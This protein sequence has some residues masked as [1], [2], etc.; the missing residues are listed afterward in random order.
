MN[1]KCGISGW[2]GAYACQIDEVL[3]GFLG[4]LQR[5]SAGRRQIVFA[6]FSKLSA[7]KFSK[8]N[9]QDALGKW[10]MFAKGRDIIARFFS[11]DPAG[12]RKALTR[13]G[14]APKPKSFYSKLHAAFEEQGSKS[15]GRILQFRKPIRNSDVDKLR[16]L[17]PFARNVALLD[18]IHSVDDAVQLSLELSVVQKVCP[19][20]SEADLAASLA[21]YAKSS[22]L[23]EF[24]EDWLKR[25]RN[26]PEPPVPGT[27]RL[28]PLR[29][30]QMMC[31]ASHRY[32]NCLDERIVRVVAGQSYYYEWIGKAD[33]IIELSRDEPLGWRISELRGHRNRTATR[34]TFREIEDYFTNQ[35]VLPRRSWRNSFMWLELD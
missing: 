19:H 35:G 24:A 6:A 11:N 10:L 14:Y 25:A 16:A 26:F 15:C 13:C 23:R 34:E 18:E 32:S 4:E 20:I 8:S 33:V 27:N 1:S 31:D 29:N 12:F 7:R 5:A 3:P 22:N 21:S 9:A 2:A 17:P 28:L 30:G